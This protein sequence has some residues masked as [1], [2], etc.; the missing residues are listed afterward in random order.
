MT[1]GE[2]KE[3]FDRLV[4]Q[5]AARQLEWKPPRQGVLRVN[6]SRSSI[7][8]APD[9][10]GHTVISIYNGTGAQIAIIDRTTFAFGNGT[11]DQGEVAKTQAALRELQTNAYN[12]AYEV[13]E[14]YRDI[15]DGMK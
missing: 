7:E 12:K 10:T 5:T 2:L 1:R 6:F 11:L 9:S 14:T 4:K 13:N 8:I 15:L 3:I